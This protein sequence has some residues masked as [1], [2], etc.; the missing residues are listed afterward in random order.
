VLDAS[1]LIFAEY[2]QN[3]SRSGQPGVGD[4]F[5]KW[6]WDNQANTARCLR[7]MITPDAGRGFVEF[8]DAAAL[9]DFDR[10]DRKFVAV[11]REAGP[12]TELHI[13]LDTDW[14]FNRDALIEQGLILRFLCLGEIAAAAERKARSS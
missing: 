5:V 8:P 14:W 10:S 6:A 11:A 12:P 3:T 9:M 4:A 7:V 2:F 13:D 1:H